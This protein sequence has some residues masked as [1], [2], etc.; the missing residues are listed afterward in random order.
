MVKIIATLIKLDGLS[1]Q[2]FTD[3]W[4]NR[5]GQLVRNTLPGLRKY[6]IN[7]RVNRPDREWPYDGVSELWFD[8]VYS[9]KKAF[10]SKEF[11]LIR[12]DEK[13]FLKE[14]VWIMTEEN[15]IVD[16]T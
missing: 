8:D 13:K 3:Y 16:R 12:E 9:I 4:L 6:V 11:E 1:H 2:E 7:T 10:A 14:V 15:L 5:H